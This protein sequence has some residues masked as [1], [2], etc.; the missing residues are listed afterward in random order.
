MGPGDQSNRMLVERNIE[1]I[2]VPL[3]RGR[4]RKFYS[5][6][7]RLLDMSEPAKQTTQDS[8]IGY[9]MLLGLGTQVQIWDTLT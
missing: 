9:G 1:F 4:A 7:K 6:K 3:I 2:F 8:K 5:F